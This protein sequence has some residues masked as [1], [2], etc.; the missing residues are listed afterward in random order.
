MENGDQPQT[1]HFNVTQRFGHV[2]LAVAV[3]K[4]EQ[5]RMVI[6]PTG[7]RVPIPCRFSLRDEYPSQI[8]GMRLVYMVTDDPVSPLVASADHCFPPD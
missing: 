2:Q 3:H 7:P 4:G 6:D 1:K 8:T 5:L